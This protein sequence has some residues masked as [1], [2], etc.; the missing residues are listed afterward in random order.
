MPALEYQYF[1]KAWSVEKLRHGVEINVNGLV[2]TV[3]RT[4]DRVYR[5]MVGSGYVDDIETIVT[6]DRADYATLALD[7]DR[8]FLANVSGEDR[9]YRVA[10]IVTDDESEP[11][12]RFRAVR[13][14]V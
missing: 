14:I 9:T 5:N 13:V 10:E 6:I 2:A 4:P 1:E 3:A 8:Q 12:L 11:T 7:F